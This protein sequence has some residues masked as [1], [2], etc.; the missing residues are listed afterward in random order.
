MRDTS[1]G[2]K[3]PMEEVQG[4]RPRKTKLVRRSSGRLERVSRD[5]T[6]RKKAEEAYRSLVDHSL[7]G[8]AIFQDSR[9]VFAN[10][11]MAEITGFALEEMLT[12][13]SEQVQAFVHPEER[14]LVWNRHRERLKGSSLP[15]Q[16]ELR[17][18]RK[19]GSICWLD[20]HASRIEYRGKPAIQAT[21]VDITER[22]KAEE[23][24]RASRD[25]LE[26]LT[27]SMWD[28]VFSVKMPGRVI[29]WVNDSF[30]LTGYEPEDC[31][32]R[33]TEFLYPDKREFI[34]FGN[35]LKKCIEA[36]KDVLHAEQL[37]RRKNG[38]PFSAEITTT[39]FREK[40]QVTRVTSIVRDITERKKAE[41]ALRESEK[42]FK[43]I[44]EHANDGI[45]YLDS[46]GKILDVNKK[47]VQ[48]FGGSKKEIINKDFTKIGIFSRKDVPEL[49]ENFEQLL[50]GQKATQTVTI[51]NKKGQELILECLASVAKAGGKPTKIMVIA[52]DIT[53]R[54]QAEE[55]LSQA[56]VWQKAIFEGSRDAVFITDEDSRFVA[57]NRAAC[58]L[59][60]YL[61]DELLR[62]RIPDLHEPED[63]TAYN[64]YHDRIMEGEEIVSEAKIL[65]KDG[66]KVDTEFNNRCI[67]I[68]G[69]PYMHTVARD[70]TER[71]RAE[72]LLRKERDKAQKYLDVAGVMLVAIDTEQRV[73]LINK[74]GCEI[75]GYKEEEILAKNWFD[76]FLPDRSR[77]IV[78]AIFKKTV[79][80]E[81][82]PPEYY[83]HPILT[84]NGDERL[85]AW[86][87]T[88]LKDD[89]GEVVAILSSGEN[90][91]QRKKAEKA[92]QESEEKYRTLYETITD[93]IA[94][95]PMDGRI[96]ECN[97]AFAEM[98][99]Y[100]KDELKNMTY[101][102]LTP[103][104]W[105]QM[106]AKIVEEQILKRGYSDE[107]EKEYIRKDGMVFPISAKVWLRRDRDGKP[108]GMWGIVRDITERKKAEDKVSQALAWQEAIFEGSR[109]AV[110]ITDED[111]R[112]VAVN[113]AA[114]ELTRYSKEELL[115]MQIPDLH[116]PEDLTA[117]N[118]YHDRIMAG[119][120]IVSEAK[121]LRKDGTKVDTEFNNRC[122]R[123]SGN[124]YMHT[125]ARDVTERK[126]VEQQLRAHETQLKSLASQLTLT[127][128]R[129]RRRIATELHD[130]I[131]QYLVIS[132][133]KLDGLRHSVSPEDPGKVL[134]E[135]CGS[136]GQAIA[137]IRSLTFD[138][139]SP[140]LHELGFEA[141][142]A[143][144]LTDPI[145]QKHGVT[146]EFED[147][148][149]DKPL[150]DDIRALLFRSVREL[151]LNVVKHA[152]ANKV[153]VSIRRISSQISVSVEDDG[154][155]FDATGTSSMT[156]RRGGFGLFSI[157]ERLEELG[158]H[159]EI[160]AEPGHGCKVVMTAPIKHGEITNGKI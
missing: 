135:V 153:K 6:E 154:V 53:E 66:T 75:L 60:G 39:V 65:R 150:D 115:H 114:C 157:R 56:L 27:N 44:F 113:R 69:T 67:R 88:I 5:I 130:R 76:N 82:N 103:K 129:E 128:E 26:R 136:L 98:L 131:S 143:A 124:L 158:G 144:W 2:K 58:E 104:R 54:K 159:L 132:K 149:Q 55:K 79:R 148:G 125:V 90:I 16:Y 133:I 70:I 13:P 78:R 25:Y 121:I 152:K 94:G 72:L 71:K 83:E 120:E 33:T 100:S 64:L 77:D 9:V 156:T 18:I 110:F 30:K 118:L 106:E 59:T 32:G 95:G 62:M 97:Q 109:D 22:K 93:G 147:D 46:S 23:A 134:E 3:R 37:L 31:I 140:I 68:S 35:K 155:G 4:R 86:H 81:I 24:L 10:E 43:G 57:V 47:A 29:E 15:E 87:N 137:D 8:L 99:G 7:Q 116:E 112:F 45:V 139:S 42:K 92:L 74:K 48:L 80:G 40:G 63:L 85:I 38:E 126:T 19:D 138:L 50:S 142:V 73:G 21:Y 34:D 145:E 141:A 102:Q 12:M 52:R 111:S 17:G 123:I 107:Y 41:E 105:Y 20:I 91:T 49:R 160:E 84:K 51:K 101:Q 117:Y 28:A 146:T 96:L 14:A 11:A 89:K 61:R 108:V 127:E 122:I 151:L 1:G 119:E 36:G